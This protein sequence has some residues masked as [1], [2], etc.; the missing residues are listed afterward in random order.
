MKAL[1]PVVAEYERLEAAVAALDGALPPAA[2]PARA[3]RRRAARKPGAPR[4]RR[5]ASGKRAKQALS[6]IKANPGITIADLAERMGMNH[7]SYL[8][9][10]LPQLAEQGLI[11][12]RGRGWH[13]TTN[14][15]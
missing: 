13:P 14:P 6:L 15:T 3:K 2:A 9:R 7:R 12:K 10:V 5:A 1:Q 8:Y 11:V 4:G